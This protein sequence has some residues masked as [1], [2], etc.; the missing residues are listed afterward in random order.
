MPCQF[1]VQE[2][3]ISS[4]QPYTREELM[5]PMQTFRDISSMPIVLTTQYKDGYYTTFNEFMLNDPSISIDCNVKLN[6]TSVV[7]CGK[8]EKE[9]GVYGYAKDNQLY[10]AFHHEFYPL[11]KNKNNF[12]F[13]GPREMTGKDFEETYKGIIVPR[14]IGRRGHN[15]QYTVD[16]KTGAIKNVNGF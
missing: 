16:L 10:I 3:S 11:I 8:E 14:Q 12:I 9:I 1:S 4:D 5:D 13:E 6:T 15:A 7:R 2:N